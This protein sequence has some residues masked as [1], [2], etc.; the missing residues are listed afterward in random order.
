VGISHEN[1]FPIRVLKSEAFVATTRSS[2]M[3]TAAEY[4]AMAGESLK[5]ARE[6]R[7]NEVRTS[8]LQLAQVWLNA[9]SELD[10]FPRTNQNNHSACD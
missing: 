5:W 10:G 3:K 8:Y 9:A 1:E 7:T 6:V 2:F 4:R